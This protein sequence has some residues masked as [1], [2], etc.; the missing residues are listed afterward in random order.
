MPFLTSIS[1]QEQVVSLGPYIISGSFFVASPSVTSWEDSALVDKL[2]WSNL[3]LKGTPIVFI[4]SIESWN[5]TFASSFWVKPY[6]PFSSSLIL[7]K[8]A[9][10]MS[11]SLLSSAANFLAY[12]RA[13]AKF[14]FCL[15]YLSFSSASLLIFFSTASGIFS[16]LLQSGHFCCLILFFNL[17]FSLIN[18]SILDC[19]LLTLS[20]KLWQRPYN[21]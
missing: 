12:S 4:L 7:A 5:F 13:F 18:S 10:R 16:P 2:P 21:N 14:F 19:L 9:A 8:S 6:L 1:Q 3:G 15:S 17:V 20:P 11:S